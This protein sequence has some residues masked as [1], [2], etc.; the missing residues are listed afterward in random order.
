MHSQC[1]FYHPFRF[2]P[3]RYPWSHWSI[4]MCP[5]KINWKSDNYEFHLYPHCGSYIPRLPWRD[6]AGPASRCL[7]PIRRLPSSAGSATA[8]P[9]LALC[10]ASQDNW[11]RQIGSHALLSQRWGTNGTRCFLYLLV[12]WSSSRP[13]MCSPASGVRYLISMGRKEERMWVWN[14]ENDGM[15]RMGMRMRIMDNLTNVPA[16]GWF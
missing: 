12:C 11:L 7:G 16:L 2:G 8:K 13:G 4:I 6:S 15:R 14:N 1:C 3:Q 10:S 9:S 5:M